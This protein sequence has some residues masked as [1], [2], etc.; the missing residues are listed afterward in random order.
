M[1]IDKGLNLIFNPAVPIPGVKQSSQGIRDNFRVLQR[2]VEFIQNAQTAP[3]STFAI[4]PSQASDG[5]MAF[6]IGYRDNAL[7]LPIGDPMIEP[8]EGMVRYHLGVLQVYTGSG[9]SLG[10]G[11]NIADI[12]LAV[13]NDPTLLELLKNG[14]GGNIGN[15]TGGTAGLMSG[16]DKT[17]L[18]NLSLSFNEIVARSDAGQQS[19]KAEFGASALTIRTLSPMTMDVSGKQ[20]TLGV[21]LPQDVVKPGGVPGFM[22]GA[23]KTRLDKMTF[24]DATATTHG[25]LTAKDKVKLDTLSKSFSR[26]N[27]Q[28]GPILADDSNALEIIGQNGIVVSAMPGQQKI[29]VSLNSIGGYTANQIAA[30]FANINAQRSRNITP[31]I[32]TVNERISFTD[33]S[34]GTVDV[35]F[36][37]DFA[38]VVNDID[39]FRITVNNSFSNVA[40]AFGTT[41]VTESQYFLPSDALTF[42]LRG[43]V[44]DHYYTIFVQAYRY[45]G[46][47][48]VPIGVMY[49]TPRKCLDVGKNPFRPNP[50]Y[51]IG[52][53]LT[54]T[55][56]GQTVTQILANIQL[57]G[58]GAVWENITGP[59][60][61]TNGADKTS[62]NFAKDVLNIGGKP[63]SELLTNLT[64]LGTNVGSLF[65][66]IEG[67]KSG[68]INSAALQG[69]VNAATAAQRLAE[70]AAAVVQGQFT[71]IAGTKIVVEQDRNTAQLARA[72]A[73]TAMD[74]AILNANITTAKS[75]DAIGAATAANGY[76]T[77]SEAKSNAAGASAV[78]AE[79]SNISASLTVAQ[80]RPYDFSRDGLFWEGFTTAAQ[81]ATYQDVAGIGRTYQQKANSIGHISPKKTFMSVAFRRI[82]ATARVRYIE[83]GQNV[84]G[85][86]VD[87]VVKGIDNAGAFQD[88]ADGIVQIV[89]GYPSGG[90]LFTTDGWREYSVE[91]IAN[92]A[93]VSR[94]ATF[95]LWLRWNALGGNGKIEII[96]YQLEDVTESGKAEV[97]ANAAITASS[98]AV[99]AR[100]GAQTL[101]QAAS[102]SAIVAQTAAGTA[103]TYRLDAAESAST[104]DASKTTAVQQAGVATN[105]ALDSQI[106]SSA[107]A[108]HSETAKSEADRAESVSTATLEAAVQAKAASLNAQNAS[109]ASSGYLNTILT[110]ASDTESNA[111]AA[112][113]SATR[114]NTSS[115]AAKSAADAAVVNADTATTKSTEAEQSATAAKQSELAANSSKF[116]AD[117]SAQA[118][119]LSASSARSNST[120]TTQYADAAEKSSITA[121]VVNAALLPPLFTEKEKYWSQSPLGTIDARSTIAPDGIYVNDTQYGTIFQSQSRPGMI[122]PLGFQAIRSGRIYRVTAIV[123]ALTNNTGASSKLSFSVAGLDNSLATEVKTIVVKS[124]DP[125]SFT[126]GWQT[127]TMDIL[128]ADLAPAVYLRPVVKYNQTTGNQSIQIREI[129][130]EDITESKNASTSASAAADTL[131]VVM[132][133][134]TQTEEVATAATTALVQAQ[135][136]AG[137]ASNL[138]T[139]AALSVSDASGYANSAAS[140]SLTAAESATESG[141]SASAA[142]GYANTAETFASEAVLSAKAAEASAITASTTSGALLPM[143]FATDGENWTI[144]NGDPT[145]YPITYQQV[146]GFGRTVRISSVGAAYITPF[147][148]LIPEATRKYRASVKA[149]YYNDG[150]HTE[151]QYCYFA[152]EGFD[153]ASIAPATITGND[154]G[155]LSKTIDADDGWTTFSMDFERINDSREFRVKFF[156]NAGAGGLG[157]GMIEILT[158]R[159][160]DVTE[161]LAAK[162]FATASATSATEAQAY[163][164]AAGESATLAHNEAQLASTKAGDASSYA[165]QALTSKNDAQG[166]AT[167]ATTQAGIATTAKHDSETAAGLSQGSASAAALSASAASSSATDAGTY[168]QSASGSANTASVRSQ[169]AQQ[170]VSMMIPGDFA[171]DGTFFTNATTGQFPGDPSIG[172]FVTVT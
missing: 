142:S 152:I 118:A 3:D 84:N 125:L 75:A 146:A 19:I 34:N 110:K 24:D 1:S 143:N 138:V 68:D 90:L 96:R 134:K 85:Q 4:T 100:D 154:F 153:P 46:T 106:Y 55:I 32:D 162:G 42:N 94:F 56:N 149:R 12:L 15:A 6:S 70:S 62:E 171:L 98:S 161:G 164:D 16:T 52:G 147:N 36:G 132:A 58:A 48:L 86:R 60:K 148:Y 88:S 47:D 66:Q 21:N 144:V 93:F 76:A 117:A 170:I 83:D 169:Q 116:G 168:S 31:I 108:S 131:K 99:V 38:G 2:A 104:A 119:A 109:D 27:V 159:I 77:I 92:S 79:S 115:E 33:N 137:T 67:I 11:I 157:D 37:W 14:G 41:P 40:Y 45:V 128:S 107:A 129:R 73:E 43:A 163:Q 65:D 136:A 72:A 23:D 50:N 54:G 80:L 113:I 7:V 89:T 10:S 49:G 105:A 140:S 82:R 9:W 127:M 95:T 158:F 112:A 28:Q 87:F 139:Q 103:N 114:A 167:T 120:L 122:S 61:P 63:V 51:T 30:T 13:M 53:N 156:F 69:Y 26:I 17:K 111:N 151:D 130:I 172:T 160:E 39:G 44:P 59:G 101:A 57:A 123:K 135:T 35:M 74:K 141:N 29:V 150:T 71:S 155:P 102:Q 18:D 22:S 81:G 8:R 78:S 121:R 64:Q 20:I 166:A 165:A 25:Y 124:F 133:Y 5:T 145:V 91:F 97:A 126:Q